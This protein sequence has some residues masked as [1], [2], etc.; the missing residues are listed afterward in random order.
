M[1]NVNYLFKAIASYPRDGTTGGNFAAN[2]IETSVAHDFTDVVMNPTKTPHII[3]QDGLVPTSEADDFTLRNPSDGDPDPDVTATLVREEFA[4]RRL[5]AGL[6]LPPGF[7]MARPAEVKTEGGDGDL[8]TDSG[9]G[10]GGGD[11]AVPTISC[12]P[13]Y[14]W[15]NL[16]GVR[17]TYITSLAAAL[18]S[19]H[20]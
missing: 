12:Y 14:S 16:A 20:I 15:T 2:E 11:N 3:Q 18:R 6:P 8:A 17:T 10:T 7:A 1:A 13:Q 19:Q 9:D 4:L 5:E